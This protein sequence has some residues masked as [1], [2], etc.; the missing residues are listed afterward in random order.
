MSSLCKHWF[1]LKAVSTVHVHCSDTPSPPSPPRCRPALCQVTVFCF[2]LTLRSI[3]RSPRDQIAFTCYLIHMRWLIS[4]ISSLEL[5]TTVFS[6]K[7]N[8]YSL[9]STSVDNASA[10]DNLRRGNIWK[11]Y[12]FQNIEKVLTV[13]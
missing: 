1:M 4:A 5:V 8:K 7:N 13:R 11:T 2:R 6:I 12:H 9:F 10:V 3:L